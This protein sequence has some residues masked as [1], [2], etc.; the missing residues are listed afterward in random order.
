MNPSNEP[1]GSP[2]H[3]KNKARTGALAPTRAREKDL[4]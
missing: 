1:P 2:A 3:P 4:A